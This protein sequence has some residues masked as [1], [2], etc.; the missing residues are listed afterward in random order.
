[1]RARMPRGCVQGC[2]EAQRPG[3]DAAG[4]A[5]FLQPLCG[6]ISLTHARISISTQTRKCA[7]WR[8]H[9]THSGQPYEILH[10]A[11]HVGDIPPGLESTRHGIPRGTLSHAA[12][13][14]TWH[15]IPRGTVSH[16]ALYP[17]QHS[18]PHGIEAAFYAYQIVHTGST[19]TSG[20]RQKFAVSPAVGNSAAVLPCRAAQR[21]YV[22]T[23]THIY[24]SIYRVGWVR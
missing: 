12:R 16:A 2:Y 4:R 7:R 5:K 9:T 1:M 22:C 6:P 10:G 23:H 17:A 11:S 14:P 19:D 3:G 21:I 13:Y 15:G 18:I 24:I 20:L 8:S